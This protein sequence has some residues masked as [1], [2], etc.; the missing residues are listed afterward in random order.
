[1]LALR[2]Y[3]LYKSFFSVFSNFDLFHTKGSL[4]LVAGRRGGGGSVIG[5]EYHRLS[6]C[7]F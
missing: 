1:M 5:V 2:C 6:L 4:V 3:Y 7:L